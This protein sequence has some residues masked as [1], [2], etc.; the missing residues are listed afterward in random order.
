MEAWYFV[1][2]RDEVDVELIND[3]DSLESVLIRAPQLLKSTLT[4][5]RLWRAVKKNPVLDVQLMTADSS[6]EIL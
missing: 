2:Y 3:S 1:K 6:S 4:K 5:L